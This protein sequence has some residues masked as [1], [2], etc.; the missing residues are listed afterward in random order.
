MDVKQ[1]STDPFKACVIAVSRCR[2]RVVS[3]LSVLTPIR[4]VSLRLAACIPVS[5]SLLSVLTPR[6]V[7]L[8][9]A[10]VAVSCSLLSVLTPSRQVMSLLAGVTVSQS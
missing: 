9:L 6:L 5:C 7:S 4:L 1:H 8:R 3:S 10:G 2:Y